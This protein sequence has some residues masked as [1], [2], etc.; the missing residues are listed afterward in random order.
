[1]AESVTVN[2]PT[3]TRI[4]L[5]CPVAKLEFFY[6]GSKM[7]IPKKFYRTGGSKTYIP[8]NFYTK[9]TYIILLAENIE[10]HCLAGLIKAWLPCGVLDG[11]SPQEVL[12]CNIHI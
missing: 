1:M 2:P 11:L 10:V 12:Q 8:K 5:R 3:V 7:Y 9:N 4:A 6:R